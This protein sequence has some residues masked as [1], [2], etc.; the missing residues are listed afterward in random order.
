MHPHGWSL[1][2]PRNPV[3]QHRPSPAWRT[4]PRDPSRSIATRTRPHTPSAGR[5]HTYAT[6]LAEA[7][8][9]ERFIS[10]Q[11]GHAAAATTAIYTSVSDDFKNQVLGRALAG[12]FEP[13]GRG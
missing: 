2:R 11:L 7:G 6:H 9:P 1:R 10:E 4:P 8:Y 12:A 13:G 3:S 5:S